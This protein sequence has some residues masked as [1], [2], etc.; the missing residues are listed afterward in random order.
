[1]GYQV[2][3]ILVLI[4][5]GGFFCTVMFAM[6]KYLNILRIDACM[7]F[8]GMDIVKHNEPAYPA[9]AW[10]E[11]QYSDYQS[12]QVVQLL[13]SSM[14]NQNVPAAVDSGRYSGTQIGE[15]MLKVGLPPNMNFSHLALTM[16]H[17]SSKRP[18]V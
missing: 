2:A 13:Q 15:L 3:G 8:Y 16:D 7:E 9:E 5:W 18:P 6:L 1:M 12:R 4:A 14:A 10:E 17:M 11:K